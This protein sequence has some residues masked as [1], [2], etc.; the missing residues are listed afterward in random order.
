MLQSTFADAKLTL[1]LRVSGTYVTLPR[2]QPGTTS[3]ATACGA[4]KRGNL[5]ATLSATLLWCWRPQFETYAAEH[6]PHGNRQTRDPRSFRTVAPMSQSALTL[7]LRRAHTLALVAVRLFSTSQ[8]ALVSAQLSKPSTL[9][10]A[11]RRWPTSSA[12]DWVRTWHHLAEQTEGRS[13]HAS[14]STSTCRRCSKRKQDQRCSTHRKSQ[15][16]VRYAQRLRIQLQA[17][18][19]G[20]ACYLH[21]QPERRDCLLQFAVVRPTCRRQHHS[22]KQ[23]QRRKPPDEHTNPS[24]PYRA[25]P[26]LFLAALQAVSLREKHAVAHHA[27]V[28]AGTLSSCCTT[29]LLALC[30]YDAQGSTSPISR[31]PKRLLGAPTPTALAASSHR[32]QPLPPG[33]SRMANA[34]EHVC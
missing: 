5:P 7:Q 25:Q 24:P 26:L 33:S 20:R 14:C 1:Q 13:P 34:S 29:V 2:F 27:A 9:L 16:Q 17:R 23:P 4:D 11:T 15:A 31:R 19:A 12:R 21:A 30:R 32:V 3:V 22:R 10:S 28:L 6:L 8:V 18:S